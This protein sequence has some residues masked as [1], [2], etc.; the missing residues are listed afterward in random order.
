MQ[1]EDAGSK[2]EAVK[3]LLLHFADTLGRD[4]ET[5]DIPRSRFK[6][7]DRRLEAMNIEDLESWAEESLHACLERQERSRNEC[8]SLKGELQVAQVSR[9]WLDHLIASVTTILL[10]LALREDPHHCL[11]KLLTQSQERYC[12]LQSNTL[13]THHLQLCTY[14]YRQ[15][16]E[17]MFS[18]LHF[19]FC[20]IAGSVT[21]VDW[22]QMTKSLIN[23][24]KH[25]HWHSQCRPFNKFPLTINHTI[26]WT[27]HPVTEWMNGPLHW[28]VGAGDD[29]LYCLISSLISSTWSALIILVD[30]LYNRVG[31]GYRCLFSECS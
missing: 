3:A 11:E 13:L 8:M 30:L 24:R 7:L 2:F 18:L 21:K 16:H 15:E 20:A 6:G 22:W 4:T 10:V 26:M 19:R 23:C 1:A 29:S 14:W 27:N 17:P 5:R 12:L 25:H 31:T 9:Y 28:V